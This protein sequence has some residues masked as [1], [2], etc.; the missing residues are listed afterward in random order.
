M[1]IMDWLGSPNRGVF[2]KRSSIGRRRRPQNSR[3][4]TTGRPEIVIPQSEEGSG[5]RSLVAKVYV[6]TAFNRS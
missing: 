5:R 3:P 2:S 4:A 1:R 6:A